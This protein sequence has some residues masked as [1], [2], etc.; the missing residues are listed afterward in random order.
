M[1]VRVELT[2]TPPDNAVSLYGL[3]AEITGNP[4]PFADLKKQSNDFALS[5]REQVSEKIAV[6][7]DSLQTALRFAAC[8]NIIDMLPSTLLMRP[9]LWLIVRTSLLPLMII[10]SCLPD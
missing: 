4:D 8:G 6:A 2:K 3:I 9:R 1:L 10:P 5:L 7:Q